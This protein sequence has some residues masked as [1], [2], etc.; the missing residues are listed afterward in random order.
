MFKYGLTKKEQFPHPLSLQ[1]LLCEDKAFKHCVVDGG[2]FTIKRLVFVT[3]SGG[4]QNQF[5][6]TMAIFCGMFM[7]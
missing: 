7:S 5:C 4:C 1:E 3:T 6:L 2:S